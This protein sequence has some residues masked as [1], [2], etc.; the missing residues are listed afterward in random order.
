MNDTNA[1]ED[2]DD[3]NGQKHNFQFNAD[4]RRYTRS[5]ENFQ[6]AIHAGIAHKKATQ[7]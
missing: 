5:N 4:E 6:M 2:E 7:T 1:Y 3:E